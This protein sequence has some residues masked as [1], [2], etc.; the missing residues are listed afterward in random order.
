[1]AIFRAILPFFFLCQFATGQMARME[2]PN[3]WVGMKNTALQLMVH[4]KNIAQCTPSLATYEGGPYLKGF[5]KGSSQNYLFLDLVVPPTSKEGVLD[6]VFSNAENEDS[7]TY[8]YELKTRTTL[9]TTM[10]S[11]AL[12]PFI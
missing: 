3:W 4:A 9:R 7:I 1:M 10:A 5:H 8:Q 11:I 2:P 12:M 6:I